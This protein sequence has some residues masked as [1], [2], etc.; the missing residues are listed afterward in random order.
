MVNLKT[1]ITKAE[2]AAPAGARQSR[3]AFPHRSN[4]GL[5]SAAP[6]GLAADAIR[7]SPRK[8]TSRQPTN[9]THNSNGVTADE[10]RHPNRWSRA[11][12]QATR[13]TGHEPRV[14][15]HGSRPLR[16][17]KSA[18]HPVPAE[19]QA[20]LG[21]SVR[22]LFA[23]A[24]PSYPCSG[25]PEPTGAL[26]THRPLGSRNSSPM[27]EPSRCGRQYA[28]RARAWK[29]PGSDWMFTVSLARHRRTLGTRAPRELT[30]SVN[31][32][33]T[34]EAD[35]CPEIWTATVIGILFSNRSVPNV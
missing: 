32:V 33:S 27:T 3:T 2:C 16:N 26:T 35:R 21:K 8:K 12:G 5:R 4:G 14:T 29:S 13:I 7:E 9:A 25:F 15:E 31:V 18:C 24:C 22:Q 11:K 20:L 17:A 1:E 6:P 28:T 10:S 30:S 23:F 19:C 34:S